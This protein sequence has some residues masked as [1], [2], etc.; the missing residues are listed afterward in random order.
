MR[1]LESVSFLLGAGRRPGLGL[2]A[3]YDKKGTNMLPR[4]GLALAA[5]A[6][7]AACSGERHSALQRELAELTK[8]MRGR[9]DP[10]PQV[11]PYEAAAYTAEAQVDPFR[12]E[13]LGGPTISQKPP[14]LPP[15]VREP[16]EAF[17]LDSMQ[18]LGTITQAGET[19]AL[20]KAGDNLY[21]VKK[22]NYL[23]QNLGVI[24]GIDDAQ[25][26]LRELVPDG[27]EWVERAGV[28]QLA[29]SGRR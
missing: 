25:I 7:L 27:A 21:R 3:S 22:G 18:M 12:P 2:P 28:L 26:S 17:P 23:G 5:A 24:T 19:I 6:S 9:V 29:E 1:R 20:V 13:R 14:N 11:K 8:D 4:I 10:L 16:L 15:R